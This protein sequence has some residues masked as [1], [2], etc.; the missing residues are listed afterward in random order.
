MKKEILKIKKWQLTR[1]R[2]AAIHA[3][4]SASDFVA[5]GKRAF[6]ASRAESILLPG[7]TSAIK[8]EA[9]LDCDRL[10]TVTLPEGNNVGLSCGVFR[11]CKRLGRVENS[12]KLSAIG[13][14]AFAD[15]MMLGEIELG[16]D[17]HRIGKNAFRS[18]RSLR[19]VELPF[20]IDSIGEGAFR[21]C[22]EL[23]TV[24]ADSLR[25]ASRELFRGCISLTEAPIPTAWS[26][27]PDGIYRDC[28]AL[29][30]VS[31]PQS[32][33][34]VGSHAFEGCTRLEELT[35]SLGIERIGAFAFADL[36]LLREV[37]I[38]HSLKSLGF[39][40]FGTGKRSEEDRI[41][42]LVENEYMAR[43]LKRMLLLCGSLGCTMVSVIGKTIEERKRERR[44]SSLNS[45]PVH[46]VDFDKED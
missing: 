34:R 20:G 35:L 17:L 31:L 15:C 40:A 41:R 4:L 27:L 3:D 37:F 5:V 18:C 16:R 38:P 29:T 44:R 43:R 45:D 10:K 39:G 9:F 36:P 28:S 26:E 22:T 33:T 24:Q 8:A 30:S 2:G 14:S 11:G 1:Y 19:S 32:I 25:V 12:A 46:L 6:R 7:G 42:L 23:Q 21:D 13:E